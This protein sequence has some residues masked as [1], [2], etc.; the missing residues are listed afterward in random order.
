MLI[1]LY[2][3]SFDPPHLGHL[4]VA[5]YVAQWTEAD[6]VWLM[7][8]G[9]NPLK[10]DSGP[11]ASDE[12][13]LQMCSLAAEAVPGVNVSDFELGLPRPSYTYSTLC[14]LRSVYPEHQFRLVIGSDNWLVF[15]RWRD[16]DRIISEFGLMIYPRPGYDIEPS[17]LPKKVEL[18]P[19][20]PLMLISSSFI[21]DA[22]AAGKSP[23]GFVHPEVAAFI[24]SSNLYTEASA[25]GLHVV[26]E[27]I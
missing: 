13:R 12:A 9:V 16:A 27:S 8:S 17:S 19:E 2:P 10:T 6:A 5:S 25:H 26:A 23:A 14:A 21:R 4:M 11:K 22:I 15:D 20:A 7:P 3:G 24:A 18:L 1:A